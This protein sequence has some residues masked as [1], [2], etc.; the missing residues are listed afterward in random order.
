MEGARLCLT[1]L[2]AI[3]ESELP[4]LLVYPSLFLSASNFFAPCEQWCSMNRKQEK[5]LKTQI[6]T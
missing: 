4:A 2:Q 1:E 3:G 5:A 6:P